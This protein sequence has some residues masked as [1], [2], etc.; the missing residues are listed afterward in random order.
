MRKK[1][2]SWYNYFSK[3]GKG[4]TE[5]EAANCER[6]AKMAEKKA[7]RYLAEAA[8]TTDKSRQRWLEERA[9]RAL[10]R[11]EYMDAKGTY[12]DSD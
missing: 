10:D 7:E 11:A 5:A 1:T 4:S 12:G 8:Q 9:R 2:Y 6:E 3:H